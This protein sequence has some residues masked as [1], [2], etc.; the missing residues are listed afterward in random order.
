MLN[1][2]QTPAETA[3]RQS[4]S[5]PKLWRRL[6]R[7]V[8]SYPLVMLMAFYGTWIIAW[9]SLGHRPRPMLDDPKSIGAAVNVAC[10]VTYGVLMLLPGV[11]V[12]GF[13]LQFLVPARHRNERIRCAMLLVVIY[14]ALVAFLRLDP[15]SVVE[16]FMD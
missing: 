3:E 9:V 14:F 11:A 16:W 6:E 1:P 5:L 15:L 7:I 2:Y 10:L 13:L 4:P 12:G 8:W